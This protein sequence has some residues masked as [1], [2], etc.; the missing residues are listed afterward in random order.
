MRNPLLRRPLA[1]AVVRHKISAANWAARILLPHAIVQAAILYFFVESRGNL[2]TYFPVLPV[3]YYWI[4]VQAFL[5]TAPR[6][7][8]AERLSTLLL[9]VWVAPATWLA[10]FVLCLPLVTFS[11]GAMMIAI[12][13]FPPLGTPVCL[14]LIVAVFA[15]GGAMFGYGMHLGLHGSDEGRWR[16]VRFRAH[17]SGGAIGAAL[18]GAVL[19]MALYRDLAP[20]DPERWLWRSVVVFGALPHVFLTWRA[21][22]QSAQDC[23]AVLGR[24]GS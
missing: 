22:N 14:V 18:V 3:V 9:S 2:F 10:I 5:S 23:P 4:F 11:I 1:P 21:Y 20:T 12:F 6:L 24:A 13:F 8:V 15:A 19:L 16:D 17:V 7:R